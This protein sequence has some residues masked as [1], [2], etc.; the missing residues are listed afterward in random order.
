[1]PLPLADAL[2]R[3]RVAI[4]NLLEP[5]PLRQL[6]RDC[7]HRWRERVLGPVTTIQ[8]FVLQVLHGNT[9]CAHLPHLSELAFINS[10]Y[11]DARSRLR[12]VVLRV[13][14][15]AEGFRFPPSVSS[16]WPREGLKLVA[17]QVKPD[18]PSNID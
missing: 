13:L 14:V 10:A 9:A 8:L 15:R 17:R 6:C 16:A 2:R 1:M 4:A 7:G 5:E 12:L 11:C 18:R 3:V